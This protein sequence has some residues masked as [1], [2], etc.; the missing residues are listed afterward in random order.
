MLRTARTSFFGSL[1]ALLIVGV[2][3]IGV[4]CNAHVVSLGDTGDT[5]QP[6]TA[7]AAAS[8]VTATIGSGA[9]TCPSGFAHPNICCS[10]GPDVASACGEWEDNKFRACASGSTTY[11]NML[12]CCQLSD[13]S[14]CID[15]TPP[16]V[17]PPPSPPPVYACG[18]AC[19][20]GW[21]AEAGGINP[22]YGETG[23]Q[24]CTNYGTGTECVS[25]GEGSVEPVST[26]CA[27][28]VSVG[29]NGSGS[30]SG[31]STGITDAAVP[32]PGPI[33]IDAGPAPTEDAGTLPGGWIDD[34]GCYGEDAGS[35]YPPGYDGGTAS[36]CGVC[37]PNWAPPVNGQPELCCQSFPGGLTLCF[38]QAVG[39]AT[40][41]DEGED[42]G[43][44]VVSVPP[45]S[46]GSSSGSSG[47]GTSGWGTAPAS[48]PDGSVGGPSCTGSSSSCSCDETLNGHSYALDCYVASSGAVTCSCSLDGI[49]TSSV[50]SVDSCQDETAVTNAFSASTGCGFPQ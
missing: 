44:S 2:I 50:P 20:P 6:V 28:T 8:A 31:G 21:W 47:S 41:I 29:P 33:A 4:A 46:G 13:P 14:N 40:P 15:S 34:G 42:G 45:T 48:S 26:V 7:T 16:N 18:F 32:T 49:T 12:S 39:S 23:P 27:G 25:Q 5:L 17:S 35:P 3:P 9:V 10:A 38:S 1:S 30:S 22:G 11:P 36:L 24:C 37:P 43:S 19:P